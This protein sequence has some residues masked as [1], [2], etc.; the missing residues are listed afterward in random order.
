MSYE[1][2]EKCCCRSKVELAESTVV[3]LTYL[4]VAELAESVEIEVV[5]PAVLL[6]EP[7]VDQ[8]E[9]TVHLADLLT[10]PLADPF[11]LTVVELAVLLA[12]LS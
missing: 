3:E 6:A 9:L 2:Y 4:T 1:R 7:E 10:H 12:N 11:A 8:A 5:G